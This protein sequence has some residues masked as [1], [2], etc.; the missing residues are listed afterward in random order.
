MISSSIFSATVNYPLYCEEGN[1]L[2]FCDKININST[3]EGIAEIIKLSD[4][5]ESKEFK[6]NLKRL[7]LVRLI[8][9]KRD[10]LAPFPDLYSHTG[11][12]K[13]YYGGFKKRSDKPTNREKRNYSMSYE[14]KCFNGDSILKNKLDQMDDDFENLR[15]EVSEDNNKTNL[16]ANMLLGAIAAE[17]GVKQRP[18]ISEKIDKNEDEVSFLKS[19]LKAGV[20][21][22]VSASID[23]VRTS[24]SPCYPV[25]FMGI[26]N[27]DS[28]NRYKEELASIP[29]KITK[30]EQE[31]LKLINARDT[32][33]QTIFK[34]PFYAKPTGLGDSTGNWFANTFTRFGKNNVYLD[35][36]KRSDFLEKSFPLLKD[37]LGKHSGLNIE[38][39]SV[40]LKD[41]FK[42]KKNTGTSGEEMARSILVDVL[43]RNEKFKKE[44]ESLLK[45]E[46]KNTVKENDEAV[47]EFCRNPEALIEIQSVVA[48]SEA[49]YLEIA[50]LELGKE[51]DLSSFLK[52]HRGAHCRVLSDLDQSRWFQNYIGL[53]PETAAMLVGST[54]TLG[55]G[56]ASA[57]GCVPCLGLAIASG[58]GLTIGG[59]ADA[60][61]IQNESN[62]LRGLANAGMAS[63]EEARELLR[64]AQAGWLFV[65]VDV[66]LTPL[67]LKGGQLIKHGSLLSKGRKS[68][69]ST[70]FSENSSLVSTLASGLP[71]SEYLETLEI[72][73]NLPKVKQERVALSLSADN[74]KELDQVEKL[75]KIKEIF[76]ENEMM[77]P[78]FERLNQAINL[79]FSDDSDFSSY[80]MNKY[81]KIAS[82]RGIIAGTSDEDDFYRVMAVLDQEGCAG[83][84]TQS[85]KKQNEI[86]EEYS[87]R[88]S[89]CRI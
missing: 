14:N 10:L 65:G 58:A 47:K 2:I 73:K 17:E 53:E 62:S 71:E 35:N 81:E 38:N 84:C 1:E 49:D 80:I 18:K 4:S 15:E 42:I 54:A 57:F 20:Y 27:E 64:S 77:F 30:L 88:M 26:L 85:A 45:L 33:D 39:L 37:E 34:N 8:E 31:K 50:R 75:K 76:L 66:L 13:I 89:Q 25:V 72:L 69:S 41:S 5:I 23:G 83:F 16:I 70:P 7:V 52:A 24:D 68:L 67:G 46:V 60:N 36:Y 61:N 40:M 74:L 43:N 78:S 11:N 9:Q 51:A 28:C 32:L 63:Q 12:S 19:R 56:I 44:V 3:D 86:I 6:D 29:D 59:I 21:G 22:N 87:R 48:K 55:F 82:N 79:R